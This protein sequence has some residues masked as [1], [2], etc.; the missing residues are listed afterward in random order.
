MRRNR[1]LQLLL[2]A[3][4][5]ALPGVCAA[6]EERSLLAGDGTLHVVRAGLAVDLGVQGPG[7]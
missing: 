2:A 6:V 5:S 7:I 4:L 1:F 3:A